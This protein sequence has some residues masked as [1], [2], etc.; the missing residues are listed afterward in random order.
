MTDLLP[1]L[2]LFS[3]GLSATVAPLTAT[4]LADADEQQRRHRVGR[5]QRHRAR[6]R[7]ARRRR[8]RCRGRRPVRRHDRRAPGRPAALCLRAQ[9]IVSEAKHRTLTRADPD[10]LRPAEARVV[11]RAAEDAAV[12]AFHRASGS[13][14]RLVALGGVLGHRRDPQPAPRGALRG[15]PRRPARGRPGR[16]CAPAP[17]AARRRPNTTPIVVARD[18]NR[19]LRGGSW[20][21]K[22]AVHVP[23]P[24]ADVALEMPRLSWGAARRWAAVP[25]RAAAPVLGTAAMGAIVGLS[26]AI[27]LVA[28]ERPVDPLGPRP[29]RVPELDGRP[30]GAPSAVAA[31]QPADA[32]GRPHARAGDP[33]HR[34]AGGRAVR[35]ARTG[36]DR[37]GRRGGDARRPAARAAAVADRRLQLP[38]LRAHAGA[39]GAQPVRRA[40]A[41]RA[42]TT[43]R[44]TARNWH[45]L[46]SPYGP[47][48]TL[49]TEGARAAAAAH[50]LLGVEGRACWPPRSGCSRSCWWRSPRAGSAA[51]RRRAIALVGLNP[52]VLVYGIGGAAQRAAR[53]AVPSSAAVALAVVGW[54]AGTGAVAGTS[55]PAPAPSLAAGLKPSAALLAPLVVLACRAAPARAGGCG[56]AGVLVARRRRAASYGGH[57]PATASR[58]RLVDAAQRAQR[59]RRARRPAAGSTPH[60]RHVAHARARA[61]RRRRAPSPWPG[62]AR[63]LSGA[64]GFV[65]LVAVLTLGWTM[66]W[67]V[68]WVLPFAALARTRALAGACIVLTAWLAL[69]A[70]PQ[71]PKRDPPLRLLP[72]AHGGGAREPRLHPAL[73]AMSARAT[74]SRASPPWSLAARALRRW[75][76]PPTRR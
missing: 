57:L 61:G 20:R 45:H 52:L 26:G 37:L 54:Q 42:A 16:G 41:H 47:L 8:A 15:L 73:P 10:S 25:A 56:G 62:G 27:V 7:A 67:Y 76:A 48:F 43:R 19:V 50:R 23:G 1:A 22:D 60:D 74:S 72:D 4:V 71:M 31:R 28:A 13:R 70:I 68:W 69:G 18:A 24:R 58:T 14:P 39:Y 12:T 63:W 33:R 32:P 9:R 64:A 44:T 17:G 3:L 21:A 11:T 75:S 36:G 35:A 66:P 5:Q 38:A 40:A 46:P 55:A 29:A 59:A 30:P 2:L 53:A 65:M 6:R 51:R 49:V 34:V